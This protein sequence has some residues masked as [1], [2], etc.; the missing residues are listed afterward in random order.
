MSCE[1]YFFPIRLAAIASEAQ[2]DEDD[3]GYT[4][5]YANELYKKMME[6]YKDDAKKD[7]RNKPRQDLNPPKIQTVKSNGHSNSA[8]SA[9]NG[10][11]KVPQADEKGKRKKKPPPPPPSFHDLLRLAE[12]KSKEPII[13]KNPMS[14]DPKGPETSEYGRPMTARQKKEFLRELELKK[15]VAAQFSGDT[16]P[17]DFWKDIPSVHIG[18]PRRAPMKNVPSIPKIPAVPQ[19]K[20][21]GGPP[22]VTKT[23]PM[24]VNGAKPNNPAI[25]V[26]H[27]SHL[28]AKEGAPVSDINKKTD[29]IGT[30]PSSKPNFAKKSS[31]TSRSPSNGYPSSRDPHGGKQRERPDMVDKPVKR[32][33]NEEVV[34]AKPR[35][36]RSSED[37]AILP[38]SSNYK[39]PSH[40]FPLNPY[41]D[42][43]KPLPRFQP[44]REKGKRVPIFKKKYFLK[45]TQLLIHKKSLL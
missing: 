12:E 42:Q 19:G 7:T 29:K 36:R 40:R 27:S 10:N 5:T 6:K 21:S 43:D 1:F 8:S 41:L 20:S 26:P 30:S 34:R 28:R 45:P 2:P 33:P 23:D 32:K 15:R 9:P 3:Y 31:P 25:S 14:D 16:L 24:S 35:P 39:K 11:G 37:T 44:E 17:E 18:E 22:K 38:S 13:L 4:S